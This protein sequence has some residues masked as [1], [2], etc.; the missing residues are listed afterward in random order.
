[1]AN[2]DVKQLI[3]KLK[4]QEFEVTRTKT[5]HYLVRKNGRIIGG[6]AST[7]SNPRTLKN[8]IADFKRA[9]FQP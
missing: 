2:K 4:E 3:K 6:L 7:P 1:M 5:N 9:G 8:S